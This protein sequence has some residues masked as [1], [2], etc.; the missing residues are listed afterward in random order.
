ME[1]QVMP[2]IRAKEKIVGGIFTITQTI[3]LGLALLV[4][5]GLGVAVFTATNNI[6]MAIVVL[7]V[8]ALPFVPFAFI[9][10]EKM[11]DMELFFYLLIKYK[12]K[13]QQKIYVNINENQK[14]RILEEANV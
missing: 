10:I 12:Y 4:G 2:D 5:G 1:Y 8:G 7:C 6:F 9:T 11:G 13:K 3:P 14:K